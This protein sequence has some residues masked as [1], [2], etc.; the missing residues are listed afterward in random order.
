MALL[1]GGCASGPEIPGST[2]GVYSVYLSTDDGPLTCSGYLDAVIREAQ[3]P[4]AAFVVGKHARAEVYRNYLE[5]YRSNPY[6]TLANHSY[7]HADGHYRDYYRHPERVLE[8][9]EK[10][11]RFLELENKMGRLPG[12]DSW[13]IG[14]RAYDGDKTATAAADLLASH[15]YTLYGWDLEWTHTRSGRPIGSAE[16]LYRRIRAQLQRGHTYTPGHLMLLM[17]DQMFGSVSA[18]RELKK[19]I[20]LLR[21]DPGIRLRSLNEYPR[22]APRRST[23]VIPGAK[24]IRGTTTGVGETTPVD[25]M[26]FAH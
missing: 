7:S 18:R 25:P 2:A 20:G 12:R 6:I 13:R 16:E 17:H 14:G 15:G 23:P 8:D 19:L 5:R 11:R 9:F 21:S 10:N 24:L 26:K 3:V 1:V 22:T 4:V